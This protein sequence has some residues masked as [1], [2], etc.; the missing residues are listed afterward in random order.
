MKTIGFYRDFAGRVAALKDELRALLAR[1]KAEG[2]RIAAYGAA[3]K[4]STLLNTFGIGAET[5]DFV[6]DR[7]T[8]KQGRFM[9]GVRVPIVAPESAE[10]IDARL[11]AAADLE[12]RRRDPARSRPSTV[13]RGGKFIVPIPDVSVCNS[14]IAHR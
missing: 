4:G 3:A 12:L 10:R 13:R 11:H 6:A 7:S 5:L 1:L 2:K 9:P 8:Y 14:V